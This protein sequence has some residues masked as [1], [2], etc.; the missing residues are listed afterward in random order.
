MGNVDIEKVSVCNKISFVEKNCKYFI[1]YLCNDNK[2][3]PLN[4]MLP[5]TSAYVIKKEFQREF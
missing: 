4:I 2:V 5:K 1:G 3:K